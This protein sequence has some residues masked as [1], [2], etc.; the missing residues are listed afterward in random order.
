MTPKEMGEVILANIEATKAVMEDGQTGYVLHT[1]D[2][3]RVLCRTREVLWLGSPQ[4][5]HVLVLTSYARAMVTRESWN[6][7]EDH[8]PVEVRL[9]REALE[10]YIAR[11]QQG[12]NILYALIDMGNA[13]DQATKV[14]PS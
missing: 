11:Q 5:D 6:S 10:A 4:D 3:M 2:D 13:I 14:Q 12:L 1:A 7:N 9:R 8:Q